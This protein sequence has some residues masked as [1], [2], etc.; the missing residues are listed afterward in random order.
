MQKRRLGKTG[1]MSSILTFGG[2]AL[3]WASQRE[4][5]AGLDLAEKAGINRIDI[6]PSYGEAELRLG[7]W[8]GRHGNNFFL[9][10]KTNLRTKTGAWEELKRSLDRMKADHFD[11]YQFHMVDNSRDLETI[12]GPQGALDAVLEARNQG[13]VRCIGITGHHPPL[14]NTALKRFDF[15]TVMFPLNR[16]HAATF[17]G[18][19]DWRELLKTAKEKKVGVLAIKSVAKK[20]WDDREQTNYNT[21]YQP[22]HEAEDIRKSL[23]YTLSQDID[24]AVTPGDL[25]LLPLMIQ[26]AEDYKPLSKKEQQQY[27]AEVA[28]YPPLRGD[29]MEF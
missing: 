17:S 8:I 28:N 4:C 20:L 11:I 27:I 29:W 10:C 23:G 25:N 12:L 9:G 18:W 24:S 13:L 15:D 1:Q 3:G 21:W 7:D 2:F 22:F 16:V 14:Y 19:N 26:A 5:D 6:A